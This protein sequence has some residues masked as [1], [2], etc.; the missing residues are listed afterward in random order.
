MG[1]GIDASDESTDTY[2]KTA[3][4]LPWAILIPGSWKWPQERVDLVTSYPQF[5]AFAESA[6]QR[7][8]EWYRATNANQLTT[9]N[10]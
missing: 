10:P 5:E 9:Y 7:S 4:N 2:F 1:L 3:N 6:G 8:K